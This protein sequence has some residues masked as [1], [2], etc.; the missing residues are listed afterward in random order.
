MKLYLVQHAQQKSEEQNPAK[1]LTER[2]F[3]DARKVAGLVAAHVK[4]NSIFHSGKLRAKQTAE[5]LAEHLNPAQGVKQA[6]GLKPNDSHLIWAQKLAGIKGDVMLVGHLPHL[7]NLSSYLLCKDA[8]KKIVQFE[9]GGILCLEKGD[10][11]AWLVRFMLV[12]E[13]LS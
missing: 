7:Q 2:G 6:E 5:V 1:P 12:P 9:M 8:N 3:E 11:S 10:E 4:V 13:L